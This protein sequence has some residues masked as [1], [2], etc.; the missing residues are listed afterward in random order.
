MSAPTE[1]RVYWWPAGRR[2]GNRVQITGR[3]AAGKIRVAF[4]HPDGV[5]AGIIRFAPPHE[6]RCPN[7]GGADTL[8]RL[9]REAPFVGKSTDPGA[10]QLGGTS[11]DTTTGQLFGA[12]R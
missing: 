12:A 8:N 11:R 9:F 3:N 6:L 1:P 7:D 2:D 4:L 5:A 10:P